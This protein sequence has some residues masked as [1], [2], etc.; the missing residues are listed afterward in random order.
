MQL[1]V[2]TPQPGSGRSFGN[3]TAVQIEEL[4]R[5]LLGLEAP[6]GR[7]LPRL[8]R[9][10]PEAAS[11]SSLTGTVPEEQSLSDLVLGTTYSEIQGVL[12]EADRVS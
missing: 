2:R 5:M 6:D 9:V 4:E 12:A 7:E 8:S 11:G 10:A 3:F 1:V